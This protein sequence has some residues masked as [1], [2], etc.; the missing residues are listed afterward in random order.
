MPDFG[1]GPKTGMGTWNWG[2]TSSCKNPQAAWEI[3]R[4]MLEPE[5]I[6][7]MTNANGAVP[8]RRSALVRSELHRPGGMLHLYI[9]QTEA[10]F[11]VPRPITPAYPTITKAFAEAFKQVAHGA[12]VKATLDRAAQTIDQDIKEHSGYQIRN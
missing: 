4:F 3:L 7:F 11:T 5:Q 2:I 12:D 1:R 9:E 8:A 10:G 6:L